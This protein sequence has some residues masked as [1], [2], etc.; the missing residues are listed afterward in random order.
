MQY[1]RYECTL[2]YFADDTKLSGIV[3]K[4]EGR[5]AIQREL[6]K[7]EKWDHVNRLRFNKS[8]CKVLHLGQDNPRHESPEQERCGSVRVGS[9]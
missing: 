7:L 4:T 5:E 3:N 2:S 1:N 8:K 9:K 6:D